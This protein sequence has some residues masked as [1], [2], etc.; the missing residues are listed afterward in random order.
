MDNY[1]PAL[2]I[3]RI[4]SYAVGC[5]GMVAASIIGFGT[6]RN[7]GALPTFWVLAA[8]AAPFIAAMGA[9]AT[10]D[11]LGMWLED[12]DESTSGRTPADSFDYNS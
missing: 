7:A 11:L 5:F 4:I 10:G 12:E 6:L 9:K 8:I 2:R 1:Y 3:G